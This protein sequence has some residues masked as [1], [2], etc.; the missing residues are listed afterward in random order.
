MKNSINVFCLLV[1]ALLYG[2]QRFLAEPRLSQLET[3]Q[4]AHSKQLAELE[5]RQTN[6][7]QYL[8]SKV[9]NVDMRLDATA[10][11]LRHN[12]KM[13]ELRSH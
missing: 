3:V 12:L 5:L 13:I 1:V 7:L 6:S 9:N 8:E 11:E 2:E 4:Q 10:N